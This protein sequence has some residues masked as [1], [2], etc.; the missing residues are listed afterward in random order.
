MNFL[1]I[2]FSKKCGEIFDRNIQLCNFSICQSSNEQLDEIDH[3]FFTFQLE[4]PNEID[5]LAGCFTSSCSSLF[6]IQRERSL[7][8]FPQP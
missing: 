6:I 2:L 4:F 5:V 3:R 1:T 7:F 8:S